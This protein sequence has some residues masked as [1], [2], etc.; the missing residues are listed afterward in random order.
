MLAMRISVDY[1]AIDALQGVASKVDAGEIVTL[2]GSNGAGKTTTLQDIPA[3][4]PPARTHHAR[5]PAARR[6]PAHEIVRS[7]MRHVPEGRGFSPPHGAREPRMGAYLR[8]DPAR[9]RRTSSACSRS[10]RVSRSG[11]AQSAGTLS[12][13][14]QQMLAIG[15]ALMA[16][17][18]TAPARRA[19][20]GP[21]ARAR[22]ST[23][24][25]RSRRS[26]AGHDRPARGA[27]RGDG[28]G[29]RPPRLRAGDR[30]V[31]RSRDTAAELAENA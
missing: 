7:G 21:R 8:S 14:E 16:R 10:F 3:C 28:A 15:R 25:R 30:D 11:A 12:G 27:E 18:A 20:H 5:R 19:A 9:S 4:W 29:G 6:A 26:T 24:S 13:G 17:A 1:G 22:G 31:S 2:I 23:S